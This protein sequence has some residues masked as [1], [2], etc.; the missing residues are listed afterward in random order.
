MLSTIPIYFVAFL[1]PLVTASDGYTRQMSVLTHTEKDC[2]G[3]AMILYFDD[4]RSESTGHCFQV[5]GKS[6]EKLTKLQPFCL[7][8]YVTV[9]ASDDC[10]EEH[11]LFHEGLD[12]DAEACHNVDEGYQSVKLG[13]NI[14]HG[15]GGQ[16]QG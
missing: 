8:G 4:R 6:L 1:A 2:T 7:N 5:S 9:Y 16:P 11:K 3:D 14:G 10:N 13:C 12:H 15:P